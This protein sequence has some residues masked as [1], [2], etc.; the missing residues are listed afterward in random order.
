MGW[1]LYKKKKYEEA[2]KYLIQ[3]SQDKDGQHIEILDHLGDTHLKLGEKPE[4]VKIWKKASEI[5]PASKRE[6][7]KKAQ[8]EKKLKANQ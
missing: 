6:E 1:V 4:A 5:K 7:Q 8:V 2:K 3:A